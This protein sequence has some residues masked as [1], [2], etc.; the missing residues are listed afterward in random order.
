MRATGQPLGELRKE[1]VALDSVPFSEP[2]NRQRA[3][4]HVADHVVQLAHRHQIP[5][6]PPGDLLQ[7]GPLLV[8]QGR[9]NVHGDPEGFSSAHDQFDTDITRGRYPRS[10]LALTA[11]D[12]LLAVVCDGRAPNDAGLTL[13]ENA[14]VLIALGAI[15]AI[16]L[17]GGASAALVYNGRLQNRPRSDDGDVHGGR[18][19][20]TAITLR[21]RP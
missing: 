13:T 6:H 3:C 2:W 16:N 15:T 20:V 17:D 7:A 8:H 5:R 19:V 11:N 9:P 10:A 18:P 4:L 21:P 1:G 14:E 12:E